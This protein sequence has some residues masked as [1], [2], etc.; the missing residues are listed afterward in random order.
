MYEI[1]KK[2]DFPRK[3]FFHPLYVL[4]KII[5]H[6]LGHGSK[7]NN[8]RINFRKSVGGKEFFDQE[9]RHWTYKIFFSYFLFY[10]FI[11]LLTFFIYIQEIKQ[12]KNVSE[13]NERK[14]FHHSMKVF[15]NTFKPF[16]F[17]LLFFFSFL[18]LTSK[19]NET[20]L[21]SIL[22]YLSFFCVCSLLYFYLFY[23]W[24]PFKV[25]YDL[26]WYRFVDTIEYAAL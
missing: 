7:K 16:P 25:V 5:T 11:F 18:F 12:I 23:L 3:F 19:G 13:K 10:F 20:I 2:K 4:L 9:N 14:V 24:K 26:W 21:P 17:I 22:L 15:Q 6:N 1:R 8:K